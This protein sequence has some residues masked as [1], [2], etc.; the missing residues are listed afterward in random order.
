[1]GILSFVNPLNAISAPYRW[2]IGIVILTGLILGG[3]FY[4]RYVGSLESKVAIAQYES[5]RSQL[6]ENLEELHVHTVEKIV[7]EYVTKEVHIHDVGVD[8]HEIIIAKIP[9][10]FFLSNGW[11]YAHDTSAAGE[12]VESTAAANDT[13]STFEASEALAGISDNYT[14][15]NETRTTL[16]SLQDWI[17]SHNADI[18]KA[19]EEAKKSK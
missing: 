11:V 1:M 13:P 9:D 7:T 10:H 12:T 19:N 8:N 4:G 5:K 14:T 17:T 2:L 16:I 3:F 6:G 18:T 15:C